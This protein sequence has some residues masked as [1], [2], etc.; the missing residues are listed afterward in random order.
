[1]NLVDEKSD[2]YRLRLPERTYEEL[3]SKVDILYLLLN[4]K[5]QIVSC[6]I[7]AQEALGYEKKELS[8]KNFLSLFHEKDQKDVKKIIEKCVV[9]GYVKDVQTSILKKAGQSFWVRINGWSENDD[10]GNQ[11]SIRFY[12]KDVSDIVRSERQ[13]GLSLRITR[14]MQG[15]L[16][17]ESLVGEALSEIQGVMLSDGIGISLKKENG[18]Y[19][20]IGQWK[21]VESDPSLDTENFRKWPP[22]SWKKIL[23]VCLETES[24][25]FSSAKSFWTDSLSDLVLGIQSEEA[26]DCL[27]PLTEF[28]SLVV[29]PILVG[30]AI[31]GFFVMVHREGGRWVREDVEFLEAIV[32]IFSNIAVEKQSKPISID[33]KSLFLMNIPILGILFTKDGVIEFANLWFEEF[34]GL[35]QEE[36]RGKSLLDFIAPEFHTEVM[37]LSQED[38]IDKR[39]RTQCEA[40]VLTKDR[41]R[42]LVECAFSR[43]PSNGGSV[44]LWYL[45]DREDQQ[46]LQEHL[47]QARKMESL[48]MLA[49]GVV[50]D[51]N[52]LL[53]CILG[54]SSLLSEEISKDNPYYEDIHQI[55]NTSKKATELTSRL[56]AYAQGGSYL[57]HDLDVNQ[58]IKEVAGILSRTLGKS[59]SI[60][61]E[62]DPKIVPI[63]ADA[64]QIQQA[65]LQVSLNARDAM[66]NGGKILFQTRNIFLGED[67]K[68]LR[69]AGKPG[70]YVQIAISDTGLGMSGEV[71]NRILEPYFTTKDKTAGKGLGLS[72]V[73]E[74]VE[75]HD[76]FISV[77]SEKE[78]GTVFK[79]HLPAGEKKAQKSQPSFKEKPPLGKETIL[80]VDDEKVLRETARKMLTRYGYKVISAE[81]GTEAIAIYKKYANRIHLII[82]DLMIPGIEIQKV[83]AWLKKFNP[84]VK[85]IATSELGV[86]SSAESEI[87][88]NV[89]GFIQKP[90]QVRPL[91]KKVR[92]VLNA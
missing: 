54:Y 73:Q 90:F 41:N 81:S 60:R 92:S 63:K 71:K 70:H 61:A 47:L 59:I 79:I 5:G 1:M 8:G 28:E 9:R 3:Y 74:I 78:K 15:K 14:L 33:D 52:N 77:F 64:S 66:P 62:L 43:M 67:N 7:T 65:I 6:N 55:S 18:K 48:G 51:F 37:A 91:L 89:A 38:T 44:E 80:L 30:K 36:I 16:L 22:G 19:L 83:L 40:I 53:S 86:K 34:I 32:P 45:I 75:N 42:R 82:L 31:S 56:M 17:S 39:L 26:R 85:I 29:I 20:I 72:M 12:I 25:H 49:G 58:L 23:Q 87:H 13:T 35:P 88:Q 27:I 46:R 4:S 57:V 11:T 84:K 21:N 76:G 50:H 69:L 68:W 10:T 24:G 2:T